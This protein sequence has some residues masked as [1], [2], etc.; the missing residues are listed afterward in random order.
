MLPSNK[1]PDCLDHL[2]NAQL[3]FW[4]NAHSLSSPTKSIWTR[5]SRQAQRYLKNCSY[6]CLTIITD[7]SRTQTRLISDTDDADEEDRSL[8]P[9]LRSASGHA[10]YR[11]ADEIAAFGELLLK[12][13][14]KFF[15]IDVT[16]PGNSK[17]KPEEQKLW[18]VQI[19]LGLRTI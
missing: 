14:Q 12:C 18:S 6:I 15:R 10:A 4:A 9:C 16:C 17:C 19:G 8:L 13:S 2:P 3:G 7:T 11:W 1:Y 5:I